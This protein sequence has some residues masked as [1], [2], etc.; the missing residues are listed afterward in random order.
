MGDWG[1]NAGVA[2]A[3]DRMRIHTER[4]SDERAFGV[5]GKEV[6]IRVC[7]CVHV[8]NKTPSKLLPFVKP[9]THSIRTLCA[10]VQRC[11]R[12]LNSNIDDYNNQVRLRTRVLRVFVAI[13]D[14]RVGYY[15]PGATMHT[16]KY[17]DF[18]FMQPATST[19]IDFNCV[20][21]G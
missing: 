9:R 14:R 12:G 1:L 15:P 21:S 19:V 18:V 2:C 7:F 5:E 17:V 10:S 11:P 4:W 6:D 3:I 13:Y 20:L 8:C 16:I